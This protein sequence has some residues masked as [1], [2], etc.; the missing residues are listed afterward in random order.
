MKYPF[1]NKHTKEAGYKA[2]MTRLV[3]LAC[4]AKKDCRPASDPQALRKP[5]SP[6]AECHK[7]WAANPM[8]KTPEQRTIIRS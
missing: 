8:N 7:A 5:S 6:G 3:W 1:G 4:P 2:S